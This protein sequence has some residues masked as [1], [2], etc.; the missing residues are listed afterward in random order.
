MAAEDKP[1]P[2]LY[3]NINKN[4]DPE[5]VAAE[6]KKIIAELEKRQERIAKTK[7][8]P[9]K[10][11]IKK[12]IDALR[13]VNTKAEAVLKEATYYNNQINSSSYNGTRRPDKYSKD[14]I[15]NMIASV[16]AAI[17]VA[18]LPPISPTP[19]TRAP[20]PTT[21]APTPTTRAPTPTTS[22]P[23]PTTRAPTPTT[24]APTPTTRAPTPTTSSTVSYDIYNNAGFAQSP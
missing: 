19:T 8:D 21:S 12:K 5:A 2:R 3:I 17:N 20:T 7:N 16:K 4:T 14:K 1:I 24:S 6:A 23:T 18:Y 10:E 15:D 22:A 9:R 13:D 11:R